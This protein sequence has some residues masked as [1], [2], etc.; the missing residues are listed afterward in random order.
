MA[1]YC[2]SLQ[3]SDVQ[4]NWVLCHRRLWRPSTLYDWD[5]REQPRR[6]TFYFCRI[7]FVELG[8]FLSNEA[9]F[10]QL[11]PISKGKSCQPGRSKRKA[12]GQRLSHEIC[13]QTIKKNIPFHISK[14]G[15]RNT[16][17]HEHRPWIIL[18]Q[19]L[20]LCCARR[21]GN[22]NWTILF[23]CKWCYDSEFQS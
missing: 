8:H 15:N 7:F 14:R 19:R 12:C 4:R 5:K 20:Y 10:S 9:A 23:N 1:G 22:Q 11:I 21:R 17:K 2:I 16:G 18:W 13:C 3:L 6:F